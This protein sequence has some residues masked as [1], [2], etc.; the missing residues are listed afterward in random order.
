[1]AS[2]AHPFKSP[3]EKDMLLNTEAPNF[4][5]YPPEL[6]LPFF[7]KVVPRYG[8]PDSRWLKAVE[9]LKPLYGYMLPMRCIRT[10]AFFPQPIYKTFNLLKKK[11]HFSSVWYPER[12]LRSFFGK[13]GQEKYAWWT[14]E[15][16]E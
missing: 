10:K 13:R 2:A 1:M 14:M 7:R 8:A 5:S 12:R 3:L 16:P 6:V 4:L 15:D 9:Y 11:K